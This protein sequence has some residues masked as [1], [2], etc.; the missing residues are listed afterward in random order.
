MAKVNVVKMVDESKVN[1]FHLLI[2][3]WGFFILLADGYDLMVYGSVIPSLMG[4]WSMSSS[5]A[6][7]IGSLTLIGGLVG[8][9]LFGVLS[10]MMGRKRLIIICLTGFS[11][12]T[13][14][15]GFAVG[16]V[17]FAIYRF[18]AGIALGGVMPIV[19]SLISEYAPKSVRSML[20]GVACT[21]FA[22]GGIL[23]ALVGS[24]I[25]TNFG[26]QWMFYLGGI[27]L[28]FIP[29]ILKTLPDSLGH[30]M[31]K[32]DRK[33]ILSVLQKIDPTYQPMSND[34]FIAENAKNNGV[35]IA[36][37]FKAKRARSTISFWIASFCMLLMVYGLG[38]WLP[39]LMVSSGYAL[40]SS[41]TFLLALN[42]GAMFG[43]IG[44]GLLADKNGSKRV[45]PIMFTTGA[46][47]LVL[48]GLSFEAIVLYLLA[49]VAGACTTGGQAVSNAY[50]SE[51]YPSHMRSTGVGWTIG[52]GRFGAI[53][54]PMIG[55]FVLD[56]SL[57]LYAN[58]LVFAI[59]GMIAAIAISF[60][61]DK[62]S[63]K[64]PKQVLNQ[65]DVLQDEL[66]KS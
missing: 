24:N 36:D 39:Q 50:T 17:D 14:L 48:F 23:V 58:F 19:V 32:N 10:D 35:P 47:A 59:P 55:G 43:Q 60:V 3:F 6:G 30:Y 16:V 49:A 65:S 29:F 28:L 25:I 62:Y 12:F 7:L 15:C 33:Q 8:N 52:I 21:G 37:L 20:V 54:G 57:P 22:V 64:V 13:V 53:V 27:P 18:T 56:S 40:K 51:F 61:Q 26:W 38:T 31:K 5:V 45:L 41:L 1:R 66:V 2:V 4:E 9:L 46:V 11:I 63:K 42:F 44:G 34:E